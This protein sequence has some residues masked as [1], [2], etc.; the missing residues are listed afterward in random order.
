MDASISPPPWRTVA[1]LADLPVKRGY[2]V[3]VDGLAIALFRVGDAVHAIDNTCPHR[4][5]PLAFGDLRGHVVYCPLHA[6]A[7][8]VRTGACDEGP[9]ACVRTYPARVE[10]DAVQ[11]AL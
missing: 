2:L 5:A 11:I 9:G 4:D 1:R 8:D 7:F 6:W 10:G 3:E